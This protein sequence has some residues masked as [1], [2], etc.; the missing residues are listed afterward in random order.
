MGFRRRLAMGIVMGFAVLAGFVILSQEYFL[1]FHTI[2]EFFSI[3][4][5]W[6]LFLLGWHSRGWARDQRL[7]LL[8]IAYLFI[9]VIDLVH[10]AAYKGMG[11][12][13]GINEANV[14]TQLWI[15][16][17][18]MESATLLALPFSVR[19]AFSTKGTLLVYAGITVFLM[20]SIFYWRIFPDCFVPGRGLT[21]FKR[22][23]E[24]VICIILFVSFVFLYF[25]RRE[26]DR[27][28]YGWLV[29]AI[30]ATIIAEVA[31]TFYVRVY[32]LSNSVGHFFKL[33]SFFC[34]YQAFIR[35]HM[36]RP[37]ST[38]FSDLER[39][40]RQLRASEQRWRSLTEIS[41]D[42]IVTLDPALRINFLNFPSPGLNRTAMIGVSILDYLIPEER[43]T[44]EKHLKSVL[45]TGEATSYE[46]TFPTPEGTIVHYESRVVPRKEGNRITGLLLVARDITRQKKAE[47]AIRESEEKYRTLFANAPIGLFTT[48]ASGKAL[49]VNPEMARIVGA[50]SPESAVEHFTDL[51]RQ[52]YSD[53]QRREAF[54]KLLKQN[55]HVENFEY[56]AV[57]RQGE[58]LWL[59]MNARV[60]EILPDGDYLIDGF[61]TDI[62]AL[63]LS[64]QALEKRVIEMRRLTSA[65]E[66]AGEAVVITN[67]SGDIVYANP[68]FERNTGYGLPEVLGKNPSILQSGRHDKGFYEKLWQCITAGKT[69]KGKIVNRRK[70]G[71]LFTEAASISPVMDEKGRIINYVAVKRDITEA[72]KMESQLRQAQKM[73]AIGALAGGIAHDFNNILFPLMGFAEL[74]QEDLSNDS[75]LYEYASE[76]L[77][78]GQRAGDLVKQILAFSRQTDDKPVPIRFQSILKEV[79]NLYRASLPSTITI[80]TYID[81]DCRPIMADPVQ[82]H[83]IVMNL[84]TNAMHA[85]EDAGGKLTVTLSEKQISEADIGDLTCPP[86]C[87]IALSVCDTGHGIQPEITERIFE[88]YFTTKPQGKGTGLGLSLVHGLVKQ[89]KGHLTVDSVLGKGTAFQIFLPA[90][91]KHTDTEITEAP[92]PIIGGDEHILLVDDEEPIVRMVQQMLERLGYTVTARLSSVEALALFKA[93]PGRFDLVITDMTMPVMTGGHLVMEI[94]KIRQDIPIIICTGY[95]E[96]MDPGKARELGAQGFVLKPI[97]KS[98]IARQIRRALAA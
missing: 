33:F 38:L 17:R 30:G 37:L 6:A 16:A 64:R 62:T 88:P 9:G 73:E 46:T 49:H 41:P 60:R 70:D 39:E 91:S 83:Q 25:R 29:A 79:I 24:Y 55:G 48:T 31:F 58:R 26:L 42:H 21:P 35:T 94:R 20:L 86:G 59:T 67:L 11:L 98:K 90:L 52:L 89:Y 96:Q 82:L 63:K 97:L 23:S 8:A 66:Q 14:A 45:K 10:T 47:A 27:Q 95:S 32:G 77:Q 43:V 68:A 36:T 57:N 78:A 3:A 2:T 56:E 18:F 13:P 75:L 28:A 81:N 65:I 71:S 4:V 72:I 50:D 74:L 40:K 12:L 15:S 93:A 34:I 92:L 1:L 54:L 7:L 76:I 53:S 19:R 87:Y 5:A 44:V 84:I 80:D 22:I 69:W 85:M 61:T 51:T